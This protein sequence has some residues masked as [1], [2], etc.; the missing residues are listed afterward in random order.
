MLEKVQVQVPLTIKPDNRNQKPELIGF[1]TVPDTEGFKKIE[2]TSSGDLVS[3]C[4]TQ[5]LVHY[6]QG[7]HIRPLYFY[8]I[9]VQI[10]I[11]SA[12]DS[13]QVK[14]KNFSE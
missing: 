5:Y 8:Q 7:R 14:V 12:N 2:A 4:C 10:H 9:R 1:I 3:S 6:Q 13:C 11:L